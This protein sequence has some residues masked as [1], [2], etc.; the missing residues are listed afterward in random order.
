MSSCLFLAL[1]LL[2]FV[3]FSSFASI[4][5]VALRSIFL[6]YVFL[7]FPPFSFGFFVDAAFFEYLC[8]I[9]GLLF[10]Y[11]EYVA[12]FPVPDARCFSI[13]CD[14]GLDFLHHLI[15]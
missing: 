12:P 11:G 4:E 8:T 1:R 14:Y 10:L 13:P 6:R 5:A 15:V 2:C 9:T 3:S 7:P